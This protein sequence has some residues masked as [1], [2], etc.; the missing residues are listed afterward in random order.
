MPQQVTDQ[1]VTP[2]KNRRSVL[3]DYGNRSPQSLRYLNYLEMKYQLSKLGYIEIFYVRT[4]RM[5]SSM[6]RDSSSVGTMNWLCV[7]V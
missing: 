1:V 6:A 3:G 5:T 7:C 4:I 2:L